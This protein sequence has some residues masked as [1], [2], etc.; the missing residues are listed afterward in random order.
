MQPFPAMLWSTWTV[1][2]V[3]AGGIG[4]SAILY[5]AGAGVGS[6]TIVDFD[7]VEESN[8]H[9]QVI[10]DTL[11]AQQQTTKAISAAARVKALNPY[12][13]CDVVLEKLTHSNAVQIMTQ[14]AY[15][16]VVDATDNFVARYLI[17]DTCNH[18]GLSLVSG[19]AGTSRL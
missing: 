7:V 8:L 6:M 16:V 3:G 12:I 4:S 5:L 1:L 17:N 19:S 9:R 11:A 18:V 14:Q 10:H 13:T 15:D 2:I